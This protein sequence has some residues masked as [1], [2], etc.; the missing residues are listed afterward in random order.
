M[1]KQETGFK[2]D[3]NFFAVLDQYEREK[4]KSG[5]QSARLNVLLSLLVAMALLG[6]Y[7]AYLNY[8]DKQLT[9]GISELKSYVK[10]EENI[11]TY[12][13]LSQIK[14]DVAA[15]TA[16]NQACAQHI[17]SLKEQ[18][19]IAG[20]HFALVQKQLPEN[21]SITAFD[22]AD[23]VLTVECETTNKNAPA[24]FAEKLSQ[25]GDFIEVNY[26][27]FDSLGGQDKGVY[28]FSIDC[29]LWSPEAEKQG[30]DIEISKADATTQLEAAVAGAE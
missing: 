17:K 12:E 14:M 24:D 27:G 8:Q 10:S 3:V 2:R 28:T 18:P 1:S 30:L 23:P 29:T 13:A 11:K 5:E 16:Y 22:Y 26:S 9:Q 20:S 19:R 7:M 21:T 25:S 6:G 15:L 4:Q